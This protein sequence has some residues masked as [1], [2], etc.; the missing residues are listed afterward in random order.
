M[1]YGQGNPQLT[2]FYGLKCF[3]SDLSSDCCFHV[4][5]AE[6]DD[7]ELHI[8]FT[9]FILFLDKEDPIHRVMY[10]S[11][12]RMGVAKKDSRACMAINGLISRS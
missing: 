1:S 9:E 10:A 5:Q 12:L 11:E 2:N 6:G 4:R 7:G 3:P 8:T